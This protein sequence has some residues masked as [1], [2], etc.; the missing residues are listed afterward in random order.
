MDKKLIKTFAIEARVKLRESVMSKLAKLGITD[1]QI[2]EI[3]EIGNDT[4]EIKDNHE[5]FT[6]ND[7]KNRA[8]LVEELNKREQQ[9]GNRQIAYDTL[10]EEVAYTWFNRLIAIRFMEVNDYL[11]ERERVLSSESG[12]KQPDIITHLLDTEMYAEFDLAT[13]ERVTELLSDS[14][15]DA[16]DE[17]YQL[18][19]IKQCN[20]LNQQLPDLFEKINDYTE[21]LFTVSY[22]DDNG[23]IASLLNIPEDAF[24]VDEGGQVEIIGWMY[25]YYNTEPKDKVFARGS[26]KIRADEI[27]AATQLFT[28]DWIV[29]YMVENSLGRYYIDQK[30]ANPNETR[31]EKEI[32]D[33]FGWQYYLPTAEQPEDVQLQIQDERKAKSDFAL[34]ELKL[35]DPSMGSGHILVYAFDVFM[36]LYEAEGQ[37]P[38][39]AS[40]L[41][42][43]NNLFGLDIDQRAFQLAYFA[44]MMKGRQ[45]S[46]RILSKQLRPNVYV[47]PNN[48]DI[49]EAELQ[50]VQMQFNDQKKAQQDLLTLAEGFKTGAELGSLIKFEGLDFENLKSGLN[51]TNVSF[52]DQSIKEMIL[53]GELLQQQYEIGITNPPYMGSS[54]MDKILSGYVKKIYPDSKSDL[55]GVFVERLEEMVKSTGYYAMITQHAWMFLSSFEKLR[56]KINQQTIINM[57]HLGTRAFEEIGGEVVQTTAFVMTPKKYK[58]YIGSYLRLVDFEN[59]K[60]KEIKAL[61]AISTMSADYLY[62]TTQ[63]NFLKIPGQ[64][65]SYWV[66]E[67]IIK[68]FKNRL[69][70]E[71]AD[72]R[73]G[74][75][76]ADNRKFL[77]LWYEVD[78]NKTCFTAEN[79]TE[80]KNSNLKWFP[81]DKGGSFRKWYGNNEYLVNWKNDGTEIQNFKDFEGKI[82]SHN[83]NLDYIFK[84]GITWSAL[85]SGDFSCR[86]SSN[87]LFDNSGS[88]IF[89]K[90]ISDTNYILGILNS[91]LTNEV[92]K[93]INPTMNY[94]PGTIASMIMNRDNKLIIN[95]KVQ[96]L[97]DRSKKDWDS[98]EESWGFIK[99][100][101]I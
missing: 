13:K 28:P 27:P 55:F 91:P 17:L 34:Q 44:L 22:I 9:T 72:A 63:F 14:S 31:T 67:N 47:V 48:S 69:I 7:V 1:E 33:E 16:V 11:P 26:R 8:K 21:L 10:V 100:P 3:T 95:S 18:V 78:S 2:S 98:R 15:A 68:I 84:P 36:Q 90:D 51:N 66:S 35:I 12:I 42:L 59:Y 83:Y 92:F 30:L 53:V 60:L 37:S 32:A 87:S 41:I 94:Q 71:F 96:R 79:R 65:I 5:R 50:L 86:Y 81:Y 99:H 101:L 6:G 82:R 74:M 93:L 70:S 97:I 89:A 54:G 45:Y 88:K 76:T 80:A 64:P 4:I 57:A 52:F 62:R 23:V 29:R 73:L 61:Y 25:Q 49:G 38:R 40:E 77:R 20:S 75:A 24:N 56:I 85:S 43:E 19:F 58:N 39:T 46:R